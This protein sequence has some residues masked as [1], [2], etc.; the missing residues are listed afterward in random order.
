MIRIQNVQECA[1]KNDRLGSVGTAF[2]PARP[3]AALFAGAPR[4]QGAKD[5][6][7]RRGDDGSWIRLGALWRTHAIQ[8]MSDG[9]NQMG[10]LG[11][12]YA[13]TSDEVAE[14]RS[15]PDEGER[16]SHVQE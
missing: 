7:A 3:S 9:R 16:L 12:H 6:V 5:C 14:L 2:Q 1:G 4:M 15:I 13:L 8:R 11:V 10:C